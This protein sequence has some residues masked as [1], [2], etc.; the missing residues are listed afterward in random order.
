MKWYS[1]GVFSGEDREKL[2]ARLAGPKPDALDKRKTAGEREPM[3]RSTA[4]IVSDFD[5]SVPTFGRYVE[6]RA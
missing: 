6:R 3:R 5:I 4:A 2:S 1:L